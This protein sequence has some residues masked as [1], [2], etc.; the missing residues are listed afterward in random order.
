MG[1]RYL[2]FYWNCAAYAGCYNL[3][4]CF[5]S[6]GEFSAACHHDEA[7]QAVNHVSQAILRQPHLPR[8]VNQLFYGIML[9]WTISQSCTTSFASMANAM[10]RS[11]RYSHYLPLK[12][13]SRTTSRATSL[14]KDDTR[15]PKEKEMRSGRN[16][17][18]LQ[19]SKRRSTMNSREAAYDE[20]EALRRAIEESKEEAR[21]DNPDGVVR[22][23]KRGR[24][25]SEE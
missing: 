17:A 5:M 9:G 22:R 11:Q 6:W 19:A 3:F 10:I 25:D 15:S 18:S 23:T 14:N 21:T 4:L 12:R 8:I 13:L 2:I 16:Q 20:A 1:K 24:S 7:V